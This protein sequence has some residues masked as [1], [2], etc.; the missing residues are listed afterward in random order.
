MLHHEYL[1][2]S[3]FFYRYRLHSPEAGTVRA[4]GQRQQKMKSLSSFILLFCC[5]FFSSEAE[6]TWRN[7]SNPR[8]VCNDF[9]RAG[10]FIRR[11]AGSSKWVIFLES[12]GL[13][14]SAESCNSRFVRPDIIGEGMSLR[15]AWESSGLSEEKRISPFMT[16]MST[17]GS[18][19]GVH[20]RDL[21]DM[22]SSRNPSFYNYNHVLIPYCS[23][24]AWLANDSRPYVN[25]IS[26][27][28]HFLK[29]F[30][31]P[32]SKELQFVFRGSVIFR[33]VIEELIANESLEV[34][35]D[36]VLAGSSA[37]GLG[38]I[39][40]ASWVEEMLNMTRLSIITDSSWFINFRGNIFNRFAAS[41]SGSEDM[42]SLISSVPQCSN[43][44][45]TSPCCIRLHCMLN[46]PEFFPVGRVPVISIVSLHDLFILSDTLRHTVIPGTEI[47][48]SV[49][50]DIGL[51]FLSII[52]EYGGSMNTT[53]AS[54]ASLPGISFIITECFQHIYLATSTLWD[55]NGIFS[56]TAVV[57][58]SRS[59]GPFSASYRYA[60]NE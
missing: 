40:H 34:S 35:T 53:V 31:E 4:G 29:D 36:V 16:S 28:S 58:L 1:Y 14:Y 57:E 2:I 47:N 22:D 11:Q 13:C 38:V 56:R 60:K 43:N 42:L 24:D 6:L 10:Y 30:Y 19:K 17:I 49:I 18:T 33:S 55:H 21:L 25:N 45:S 39:N 59:L 8:A 26:N 12:G 44:D 23:S 3:I 32:D 41:T 5:L 50:P 27:Q 54:S 9:S 48:S 37:G 20:G 46:S 52:S 15:Q 7:I 51:N